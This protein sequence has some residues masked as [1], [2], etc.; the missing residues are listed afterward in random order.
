MDNKNNEVRELVR[1]AMAEEIELRGETEDGREYEITATDQG[2][3]VVLEGKTYAVSGNARKTV[4]PKAKAA[5]KAKAKAKTAPKPRAKAAKKEPK[6]DTS[7][8]KCR[9]CGENFKLSK[10]TPY[11]DVCPK[12]RKIRAAD[13]RYLDETSDATVEATCDVTGKKFRV[14]KYTPYVTISPEGK[15]QL[16]ADKAA[17]AKAAKKPVAK[18]AAKKAPAKKAP[19]KK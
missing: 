6:P 14:S 5:S 3:S 10:F 17:K 16:A 15:K 8:V 19:A 7:D 11:H 4:A 2:F 13:H 18:K 1:A 12:C 9:D